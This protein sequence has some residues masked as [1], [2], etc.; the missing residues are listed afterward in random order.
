M[1]LINNDAKTTPQALLQAK[2]V[3][4]N[5]FMDNVSSII[6]LIDLKFGLN[7]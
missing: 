4:L 7:A 2:K 1:K 6:F 3:N 5:C